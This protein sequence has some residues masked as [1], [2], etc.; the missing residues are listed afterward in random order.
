MVHPCSQSLCGSDGVPQA[1]SWG[2][3]W[4]HQC[5]QLSLGQ[6]E[7][8]WW[9]PSLARASSDFFAQICI[10]WPSPFSQGRGES[11]PTA[12]QHCWSCQPLPQWHSQ[13]WTKT[14]WAMGT[15]SSP[16]QGKVS[17]VTP[18]TQHSPIP[19]LTAFTC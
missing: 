16:A 18:G 17:P 6:V 5:P 19:A 3:S 14:V 12:T 9:H 7:F 8:W 4:T 10:I 2:M 15:Q 11:S 1:E 13:S